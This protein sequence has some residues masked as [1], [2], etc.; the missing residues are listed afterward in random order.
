MGARYIKW[1]L[2]IGASKLLRYSFAIV[3]LLVMT[4]KRITI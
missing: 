3:T 1:K 2:L 4:D